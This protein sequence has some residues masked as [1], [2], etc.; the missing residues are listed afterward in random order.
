MELSHQRIHHL[1][2]KRMELAG[3]TRYIKSQ[4]RKWNE[5]ARKARAKLVARGQAPNSTDPG[6]LYASFRRH[7]HTVV[8]PHARA[9]HLAD[10]FLR[11]VPYRVMEK[12][13]SSAPVWDYVFQNAWSFRGDRTWNELVDQFDE[14][15][16]EAGLD[17]EW[18]IPDYTEVRGVR[19]PISVRKKKEKAEEEGEETP[20]TDNSTFLLL[21]IAAIALFFILAVPSITNWLH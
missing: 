3:E 8:R 11:G 18:L 2:V 1:R 17:P 20:A 6:D 5:K 12:E 9:A 4:E 14:W 13:G 7:R 15:L 19:P 16:L 21:M 10:G